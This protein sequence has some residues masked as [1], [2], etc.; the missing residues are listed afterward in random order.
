MSIYSVEL[1]PSKH[2]AAQSPTAFPRTT[3]K[4]FIA[5]FSEHVEIHAGRTTSVTRVS[6]LNSTG[7]NVRG[8]TASLN[9]TDSTNNNRRVT[10]T[11]T[12]A[13]TELQ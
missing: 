1:L 12:P 6:S 13:N 4:H 9:L 10:H 8:A 11:A 2:G 7:V 5:V 3:N